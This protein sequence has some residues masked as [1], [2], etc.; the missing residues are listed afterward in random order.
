[1]LVEARRDF[2]AEQAQGIH[3]KLMRNEAAGVEFCQDTVKPDLL[4]QPL[5]F[6]GHLIGCANNHLVAQRI[7]VAD[8]LQALASLG[9]LLYG[10]RSRQACRSLE[11]FADGAKEMHDAFFRLASC[12]LDGFSKVNRHA[13]I[14]L[15]CAGWP[16]AQ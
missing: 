11:L 16:A 1:M 14:D 5:Q 4:A 6:F 13:Q 15:A 3:H 9:S 10:A 7:L 12:S 2:L 8:A